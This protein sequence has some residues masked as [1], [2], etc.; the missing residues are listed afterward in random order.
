MLG[1]KALWIALGLRQ[2]HTI[3]RPTAHVLI[4]E[5]TSTVDTSHVNM[6]MIRQRL[7]KCV[8]AV[9]LDLV[10]GALE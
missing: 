6:A 2:A 7:L 9:V 4:R 8:F 10:E 3:R 5:S 1:E